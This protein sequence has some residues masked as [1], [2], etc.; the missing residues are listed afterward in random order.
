MWFPAPRALSPRLL[1]RLP[2][3]HRI[4]RRTTWAD[5]NR[6]GAELHSFLQAPR[7]DSAG[8]LHVVDIPFGRIFR[9]GPTQWPVVAEYEG[10]PGGLATG[11]ADSLLVADHRHGLLSLDPASGAIAPLLETARGEGFRGLADACAGPGG[12]VL[13]S[14]GGQ[15]GMQDPTG[16]VWRLWPDGRVD[17]LIGNGPGP[18][19]LA[20]NRAGTHCYV[21]MAP[22]GEVWR[23][24]LRDDALVARAG[25]FFRAPAGTGGPAGLAVDAHDRLFIANPGHGM[26][27][28]VDPFGAPLIAIDC[29]AFGRTPTSLC[30]APDGTTLLITE[31]DSGSVLSVEL[32]GG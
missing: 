23:F 4:S 10:W 13:L 12:Q 18:G 26:V 3:R 6:D 8:N 32:P 25:V 27:W 2:E 24:A 16:R 9:V 15:T 17:K 30:L 20:L 21:A 31:A 5:S 14:D 7:F 19:G 28:G 22:S 29:T 11:P 1:S